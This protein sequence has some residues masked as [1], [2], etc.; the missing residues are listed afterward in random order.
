M[1]DEFCLLLIDDDIFLFIVNHNINIIISD[2]FEINLPV[3]RVYTC[4]TSF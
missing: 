3:V 2:Y 1:C 4:S